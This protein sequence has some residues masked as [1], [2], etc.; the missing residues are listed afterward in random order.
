MPTQCS[1]RPQA[2]NPAIT[3][4]VCQAV[5]RS[6]AHFSDPTTL[7]CCCCLLLWL[8]R[9]A[10]G[11]RKTRNQLL[12]SGAVCA[13]HW[14]P[15]VARPPVQPARAARRCPAA[16]TGAGPAEGSG[17]HDAWCHCSVH[18][19]TRTAIILDR[20]ESTIARFLHM[21]RE[22]PFYRHHVH[23]NSVHKSTSG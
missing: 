2:K 15:G 10:P 12:R 23:G 13:P 14:R 18:G 21:R 8:L 6:P 16:R 19:N 20:E 4:V 5:H 9:E 11:L 7:V 22:R 1:K 17:R 3:S